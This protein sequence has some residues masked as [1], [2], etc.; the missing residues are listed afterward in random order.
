M[1][2]GK[3]VSSL[4]EDIYRNFF[5]IYSNLPGNSQLRTTGCQQ[6]ANCL[7]YGMDSGSLPFIIFHLK[8][9]KVHTISDL[10]LQILYRKT[11]IHWSAGALVRQ[12]LLAESDACAFG[13]FMPNQGGSIRLRS[14]RIE[15]SAK[16]R[17]TRA[18][19]LQGRWCSIEIP[20]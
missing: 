18:C 19:A 17:R 9:P 6:P 1:S 4:R 8:Q 20:L 3:I 13:T 11:E 16:L 10:I 14:S 2:T 7:F 12:S 15:D 5:I